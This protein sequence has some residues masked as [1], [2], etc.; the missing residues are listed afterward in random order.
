MS[1][2][3]CIF[4]HHHSPFKKELSRYNYAGPV[5]AKEMTL[6]RINLDNATHYHN[7]Q[8]NHNTH[9][10]GHKKQR[11]MS[12]SSCCKMS[13]IEAFGIAAHSQHRQ[14]SVAVY[15]MKYLCI[16]MLHLITPVGSESTG[17][18][19]ISGGSTKQLLLQRGY[20]DLAQVNSTLVHSAYTYLQSISTMLKSC[21]EVKEVQRDDRET[22]KVINI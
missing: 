11:V 7:M 9:N 14:W 22:L 2:F 12:E 20:Q 1:Y 10:S 13:A 16:Q 6:A 4:F 15:M 8:S 3:K 17:G 21:V 19:S 5:A 18:H